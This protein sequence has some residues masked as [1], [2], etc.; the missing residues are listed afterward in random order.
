[1]VIMFPRTL[2]LCI[3]LLIGSG[4]ASDVPFVFD[5]NSENV[6]G[7]TSAQIEQAHIY[8]PDLAGVP[9]VTLATDDSVMAFPV[10]GGGGAAEGTT[11]KLVGDLKKILDARVEPDNSLVRDEALILALKYPGDLTI[12]QICSIYSYLK[13]G[14]DSKKGWGYVRDPRGL[15]YFSYANQT[16]RDGERANCVGGG[17]CD[18]FAILMAALVESVGGTSR[19]ILA[20]NNT[21]GG[22]AYTEVYLGHLSARGSQ[23]DA[24][25]DWLKG[26]FNTD[27]I[28]T[29]IDTDT[30]DV[31]LNLDWG[32]DEKG[33]THPGGPFFRGDKHIVLCIRDKFAKSP[34]KLSEASQ[35]SVQAN[36]SLLDR[37]KSSKELNPLSTDQRIVASPSTFVQNWSK[38]FH[39]S[40]FDE[41]YSVQ[42]TSDGGYI[43]IGSSW[44]PFT[45]SLWLIKTDGSG[46]KKWDKSFEGEMEETDKFAAVQQT[47]DDGYIIIGTKGSNIDSQDV[48]LIKTDANGNRLWDRTFG[49]SSADGG[50]SVQET[51]DGGY[52]ITGHTASFGASGGN[53]WL[54][55]TDEQGNKLWDRT[56]GGS[57]SGH[58]VRQTTD[59]GY[60]ITGLTG[61]D[62]WL[63][64]TDAQGNKLWD[65]T[66]GGLGI[67]MGNSVQQTPDGGYIIT[68]YTKSFGAGD[69]DL[70][71]IKT[72]AQGN[73]LWDRTFGGS[74]KD[75]GCSVQRTSDSGYIITGYT[76][77][78]G[79]GDED[80]W[81]IKTDA[82]GNKLWDRTFGGSS[83]DGGRSVQQTPDGGYIIIGY[84]GSFGEGDENL[85][86]IKTDANGQV[87]V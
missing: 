16:I 76:K 52:I 38:T 56:F 55:K 34:L 40:A 2:W 12:D 84:T 74:G 64:K 14:D 23:V 8:L 15:D 62:V 11:D 31:W 53:L 67:D 60:I 13:N 82:Q 43:G 46:N 1:M 24:I 3:I 57:S 30:K 22:H 63:I 79:A 29:H 27:K 44:I 65:R 17:D 20:R 66:F 50:R 70:W 45:C 80:L 5:E 78:F 73:K 36:N 58:S 35:E 85:W 47:V 48:W 18:D 32:P 37:S 69:E 28:Y 9:T 42:Q 26:N 41:G 39:E 49:G 19:I 25:I 7:Y 33:N 59:G 68:G 83:Y 6:A 61:S 75:E 10:T 81:L 86:M 21:T 87:Q 71:L 4:V 51:S 54:I 77:S 72:D